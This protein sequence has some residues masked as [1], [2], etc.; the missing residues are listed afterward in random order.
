MN[1][2]P[3]VFVV[4]DDPSVVRS[5]IWLIES[6]PLHVETYQSAES[7]LAA[8]DASR[9]GCLVLDVRMPHMSGLQLQA[10]LARRS[11]ALPIII[12][13]GHGDVA[14]CAQVFRGGGFDF[15]EKPAND[16]L[17][18]ER[19]RA[20]I[21]RDAETRRGSVDERQALTRLGSLTPRERE[22]CT[23]VAA[24]RS[25]KQI[26]AQL[27]IGGQTV[28]KHRTR[29]MTKLGVGTDADLAR[30]LQNVGAT[31]RL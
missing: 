26:S 11:V 6:V 1:H 23:L 21:D 14:M 29:G 9:P 20:A 2:E 3:T 19:I 31:E 5:L 22:V 10:E 30:L 27:A 8:Y 4:D 18:L 24:G 16:Q 17:L 7:F 15:L 13:T 12:M 25:I 28:A